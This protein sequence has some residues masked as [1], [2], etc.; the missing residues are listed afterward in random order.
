M[1]KSIFS[2]AMMCLILVST[3]VHAREFQLK[4]GQTTVLIDLNS[5]D[6]SQDRR[7]H[8]LERAVRD[9]QN[10]VWQLN[11]QPIRQDLFV[12]IVSA[13][14]SEYRSEKQPLEYDARLQASSRCQDKY[15]RM[16]C[17]D[18]KCQKVN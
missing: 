7:I 4:N 3:Q 9:L 8:Q 2:G 15:H 18:I 17:E 1:L 10:Q 12:C 5:E 6:Q 13:F 11:L 16:H 14:T